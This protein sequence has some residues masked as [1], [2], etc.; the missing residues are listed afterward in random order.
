MRDPDLSRDFV[1]ADAIAHAVR[2]PLSVI[3]GIA[4]VLRETAGPDAR[5]GLDKI[6]RE[7][8]RVSR[9]LENRVVI[10]KLGTAPAVRREWVSVEEL[11]GAALARLDP[12]FAGRTVTTRLAGDLVAH[13]D[14]QLGELCLANL[15]DN[16]AA[17][18]PA[19]TP[20]EIAARRIDGV[21]IVEVADRGPGLAPNAVDRQAGPEDARVGL[22]ACRTIAA[23][24]GGSITALRRDGG[25]S[26]VRVTF[27]DGAPLPAFGEGVP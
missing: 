23:A 2:S 13:V 4:S 9:M 15:L 21:V 19:E 3:A 5:P 25:G 1:V 11:V 17:H 12:V 7:A 24:H 22:V 20:T 6:M 8:Q 27:P 26:I 16:V 10:A 18:T 14:A